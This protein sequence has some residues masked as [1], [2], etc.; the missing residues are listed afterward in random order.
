MWHK[1]ITDIAGY[2]TVAVFSFVAGLMI[3]HTKPVVIKEMIEPPQEIHLHFKGTTYNA[4]Y[5]D[6][7][8]D[9]ELR[10]AKL[11]GVRS[12]DKKLI[13]KGE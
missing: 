8:F 11:V 5:S 12:A 4:I 10:K 6:G 3:N 9:T 2:S 13:G 7:K 1:F